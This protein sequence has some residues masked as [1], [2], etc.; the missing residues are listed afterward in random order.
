MTERFIEGSKSDLDYGV[1]SQGRFKVNLRTSILYSL[2][3]R[4]ELIERQKCHV[5]ATN[6]NSI[7][8]QFS[9]QKSWESQE[10]LSCRKKKL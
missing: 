5:K 2:F 3:F 9:D 10:K 4:F 1:R 6:W 7:G 8:V